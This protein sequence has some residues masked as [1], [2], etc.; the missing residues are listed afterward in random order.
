[1]TDSLVSLRGCGGG[2]TAWKGSNTTFANAY[3]VYI[4]D[5]VVQK[6]NSS[7]EIAG[8][9][10]LGR[11][12]NAQHRSIFANNYLDDS[13]LPG[14]YVQWQAADPRVN[15]SEFLFYNLARILHT[16]QLADSSLV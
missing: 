3:G 14:G 15:S 5:S 9:C 7:L 10:A 2:I 13:I 16:M 8:Q 12:W 11:P 1:M 4:H 6:A